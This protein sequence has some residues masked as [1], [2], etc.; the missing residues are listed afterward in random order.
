MPVLN[1][2]NVDVYLKEIKVWDKLTKGITDEEKSLMLWSKLP[3]ENA[4]GIKDKIDP[5]LDLT[6]EKFKEIIGATFKPNQDVE[7]RIIFKEFCVNEE[8]RRKLDETMTDY[9]GMFE[10]MAQKAE[11]N[12]I[13]FGKVVC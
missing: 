10:K 2:K 13:K 8:R 6:V 1:P 9:I 4:Q 11:K 5:D 7:Q 3:T 12:K